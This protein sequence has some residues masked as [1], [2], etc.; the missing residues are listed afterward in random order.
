MSHSQQRHNPSSANR[1]GWYYLAWFA[2]LLAG[3]MSLGYA[4]SRWVSR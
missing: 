1:V 2:L 4:F 3:L